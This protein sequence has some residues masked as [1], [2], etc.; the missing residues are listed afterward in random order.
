MLCVKD[1]RC[2]RSAVA[3]AC[4]SPSTPFHARHARRQREDNRPA[5]RAR[6]YAQFAICADYVR[7]AW[8]PFV[9]PTVFDAVSPFILLF[10]AI[11]L[12][13][14]CLSML[15]RLI[16][17]W[18]ADADDAGALFSRLFDAAMHTEHVISDI[19]SFSARRFFSPRQGIVAITIRFFYRDTPFAPLFPSRWCFIFFFAHHRQQGG[20]ARETPALH[21]GSSMPAKAAKCVQG[22][23]SAGT[24]HNREYVASAVVSPDGPTGYLRMLPPP[25]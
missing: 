10:D 3:A 1:A 16:R 18:C 8:C 15:F 17:R 12:M 11:R 24:L 25:S 19:E 22:I 21:G 13:L 20:S 9:A 14:P 23:A 7:Y 5:S 4:S 6:F 2:A